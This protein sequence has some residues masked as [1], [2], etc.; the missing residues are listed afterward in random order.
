M[1]EQTRR[2]GLLL[3]F[4]IVNSNA[5]FISDESGI[6]GLKTYGKNE[7]F[8]K[9]VRRFM[10]FYKIIHDLVTKYSP[11][12]D[13]KEVDNRIRAFFAAYLKGKNRESSKHKVEGNFLILSKYLFNGS[14]KTILANLVVSSDITK[15]AY[16]KMIEEFLPERIRNRNEDPKLLEQ[17]WVEY[18]EAKER[19]L[20]TAIKASTPTSQNSNFKRVKSTIKASTPT[21][22]N[23]NFKRVESTIKYIVAVILAIFIAVMVGAL[24][25]YI[26]NNETEPMSGQKTRFRAR[27]NGPGPP[28]D[29]KAPQ[30]WSGWYP[31]RPHIPMPR[32]LSMRAGR[33]VVY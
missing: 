29:Q 13:R 12:T 24:A 14:I 16:D 22:Q 19:E 3:L 27:L 9:T 11:E 30:F 26:Y 25:M 23:S 21:S 20:G 31:R 8:K 5:D 18:N 17:D 28:L 32:I 10:E 6:E 7:G 33:G 1:N 15:D 4:D 2:N